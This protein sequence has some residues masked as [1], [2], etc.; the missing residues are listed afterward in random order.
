MLIFQGL[1]QEGCES[2]ECDE[3]GAEFTIKRTDGEEPASP[4]VCPYCKKGNEA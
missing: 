1:D 2:L 3:C 4:V